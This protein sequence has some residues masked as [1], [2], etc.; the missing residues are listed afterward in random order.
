MTQTVF[1]NRMVAH[2]WA[3]QS[4]ESGRSNNGQFYFEG[5][6]IYSYGRHYIAGYALPL[7]N[8]KHLF[9][10]NADKYSPTTGKHTNYVYYAIPGAAYSVP[11]LT[12]LASMME[13]GLNAWDYHAAPGGH[14][15]P[16]KRPA[17]MAERRA[18]LP[19]IK[20]AMLAGWP[21]DSLASSI[22]AAFGQRSP[23]TMAA[24]MGRKVISEAKREEER[25]AKY[26][27]DLNARAAKHFAAKSPAEVRATISAILARHQGQWGRDK[28][29]DESREALQCIK[30]A[31]ARGWTRIHAKLTRRRAMI[32]AAIADYDNRAAM[33]HRQASKREA[34]GRFREAARNCT[35]LT[36]G[37]ESAKL[38][39][40]DNPATRA[41]WWRNLGDAVDSIL[42]HHSPAPATVSRLHAIREAARIKAAEE[43]EAATA[44][45]YAAEEEKRAAWIRG[46]AGNHNARLSDK[47]GGALLR[48]ADVERDESGVIIGGVLQTSHGAAVPLTHALRV[49]A[50]LR[51][52]RA[53]G[54]GWHSNGRALRV[55]H[56]HVDSVAANGDF[57]AGC[58]RINWGEVERI[59]D[60]LNIFETV[61]AE[62]TTE[63]S[64]GAA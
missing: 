10:V 51:H 38:A 20:R 15:R 58:H 63:S 9:L 42:R 54:A 8:G 39:G 19:A 43:R 41:D 3:Q 16:V 47:R 28:L 4:Q 59:A 1:N 27:R 2:V 52:C 37:L 31:K 61:T 64:R 35:R 22:L 50:F 18:A 44:A 48:A 32:R 40:D 34:I 21:G 6:A 30:E 45:R 55:G 29:G 5:R 60:S 14:T 53:T 25:R 7:Q 33:A 36:T 46:E 57:V 12:E 62:D 17:T 13:S 49:F 23:E 56:F 26:A 24:T 11:N